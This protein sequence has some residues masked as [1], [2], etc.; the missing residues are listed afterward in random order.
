MATHV[1]NT[2]LPGDS[3]TPAVNCATH[4]LD[5]EQRQELALQVLARTEPVTELSVRYQVSRKFLYQQ[6]DKGEQALTQA[7]Q[8]PPSGEEEVLFYLPV[9]RAWLRQ[10]V[11]GLVL[12]CHSSYRGVMAFFQD[13]LDQPIAL[14]TV[15]NI[16]REA[17]VEARQINARQD[18]SRVRAGSHDELFQGRQPVLVGMDLD[19]TY[20][21]LLA[22]EAHRDAETW[23]IHLWDLADQ[24]LQPDYVVADGGQGL[25]AGQALAWPGWPATAMSFTGCRR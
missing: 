13:L 11:L 16:V 19:S 18:L 5:G 3:S 4:A 1:T 21:Y 2:P 14:G 20:C 12:L 23:A 6:A 17:V 8:S 10:V 24:G 7:F 15:H 25:R 9:T 22:L